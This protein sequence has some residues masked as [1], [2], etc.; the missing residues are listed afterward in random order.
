[1]FFVF[2]APAL[3]LIVRTTCIGVVT[4]PLAAPANE[5]EPLRRK[6][7]TLHLPV[8][9]LEIVNMIGIAFSSRHFG[10]IVLGVVGPVH[11]DGT[12]DMDPGQEH[13]LLAG[14]RAAEI[15]AA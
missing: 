8:L 13:G 7:S 14:G 4:R 3:A 9:V 1:M 2:D 6:V 10:G 15:G 5:T 11:G 12:S